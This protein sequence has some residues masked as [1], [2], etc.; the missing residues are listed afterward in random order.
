[1]DGLAKMRVEALERKP[2]SLPD[3]VPDFPFGTPFLEPKSD[4]HWP[5]L[6]ERDI[7]ALLDAEKD[8]WVILNFWA[9]WCAPCIHELP[10]MNNAS[11]PLAEIGVSLIALNVDPMGKDTPESIEAF[12]AEK[13]IDHLTHAT[14]SGAD[15]H[16][17]MAAG[18]MQMPGSFRY[19]L[20]IV[21][22]P[23]GVPYGHFEG[24]PIPLDSSPVWN[25]EEMLSFFEAL[26][27]SD[28]QIPR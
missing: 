3:G 17:A 12:L 21:F 4:Y 1:M 22:A 7:Q 15:I 8:N 27:A 26:V 14:T 10:D 13:G 20:N 11:A 6:N 24:L 9:T 23:G 5:A 2:L 28:A 18:G 19:P 16:T 25:S